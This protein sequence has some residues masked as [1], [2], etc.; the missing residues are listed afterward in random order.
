M[1]FCSSSKPN[2]Q[3]QSACYQSL[4]FL[5]TC[6][7]IYYFTQKYTRQVEVKKMLVAADDDSRLSVVR[8]RISLWRSWWICEE[9]AVMGRWEVTQKQQH[10]LTKG[11]ERI[12]KTAARWRIDE[13]SWC[14]QLI[15][16]SM[17]PDPSHSWD[18]TCDA[19]PDSLRTARPG[20]H[21]LVAS[22]AQEIWPPASV[23]CMKRYH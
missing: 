17:A 2:L 4:S 5:W 13:I 22:S 15:S 14:E 8:R 12:K 18:Q 23:F 16:P 6:G 3:K 21:H 19:P 20:W 1:N 9:Q 10:E 11:R 7:F